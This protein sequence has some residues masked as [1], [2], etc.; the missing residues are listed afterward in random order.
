VKKTLAS[1]GAQEEAGHYSANHT[2]DFARTVFQYLTRAPLVRTQG[3]AT[4]AQLPHDAETDK[5]VGWDILHDYLRAHYGVNGILKD[6]SRDTV[7]TISSESGVQ[8]GDPLGSLLLALGIHPLLIAVG[9]RHPSVF[10]SAYA[11]NCTITGPLTK[12]QAAVED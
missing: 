11:D 6:Y 9:S 12:V 3:C 1:L 10:L 5:P 4:L 8:Q 2:E 7:H